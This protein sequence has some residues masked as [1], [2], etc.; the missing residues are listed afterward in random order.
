MHVFAVGNFI[1]TIESTRITL[2]KFNNAPLFK[3]SVQN[4]TITFYQIT[5]T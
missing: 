1:F 5:F 4:F 2:L 3:C